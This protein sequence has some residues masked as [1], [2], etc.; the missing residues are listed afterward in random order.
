MGTLFFLF[1]LVG[2]QMQDQAFQ[3]VLLLRLGSLSLKASREEAKEGFRFRTMAAESL[4]L[5][6]D[7]SASKP[8]Y[9]LD[10]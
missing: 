8:R 9:K 6:E 4:R 10:D 1:Q 5:G 7:T 2:V 3:D